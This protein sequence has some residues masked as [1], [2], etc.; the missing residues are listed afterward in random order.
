MQELLERVDLVVE[1]FSFLTAALIALGSLLAYMKTHKQRTLAF[2]G[3]FVFI[4]VGALLSLVFNWFVELEATV[5]PVRGYIQIG[6]F[7]SLLLLLSMLSTIIGFLLLFIINERISS[8]KEIL[9]L[10]LLAPLGTWVAHEIYIGYHIILLVLT[11]MIF[12]FYYQAHR[13]SCTGH[14]LAVAIAFAALLFS[15]V[16][17]TLFPVLGAGI[18]VIGQTIR[19]IGFTILLI[20]LASIYRSTR[21]PKVSKRAKA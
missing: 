19:G 18:Y 6:F 15:Q 5:V 10:L 9:L 11:I 1:A 20:T 16:A 14:S 7:L 3:A 12:H 21:L 4:A 2:S 8:V 17:L 13:E